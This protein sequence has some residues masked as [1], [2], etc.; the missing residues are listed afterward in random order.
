[1]FY[2]TSTNDSRHVQNS[3]LILFEAIFFVHRTIHKLIRRIID[4]NPIRILASVDLFLSFLTGSSSYSRPLPPFVFLCS[5]NNSLKGVSLDF[6]VNKGIVS[7][8]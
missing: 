4:L 7:I 1:M 3:I 5:Y 2:Q 8:Y 6:I